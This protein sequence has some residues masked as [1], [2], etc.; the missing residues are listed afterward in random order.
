MKDV[1]TRQQD[2]WFGKGTADEYALV[3]AVPQ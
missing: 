1:T 3:A 2:H